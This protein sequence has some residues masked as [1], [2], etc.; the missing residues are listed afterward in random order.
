M[1]D[2]EPVRVLVADDEPAILELLQA[3]LSVW[4]YTVELLPD[5]E[6]ALC[7][8]LEGD[9]D[10]LLFDFQMPRMTGLEALRRL[11]AAGR[12]VPAILMSG[13]FS[14]PIVRESAAVAGIQLLPK[15]FTLSALRETVLRG[16]GGEAPRA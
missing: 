3:V 5:G 14:E 12:T 8:A 13:Y 11:R 10:L 7:R 2:P 1:P 4:G 6:A 9:Y 15:P 16:I